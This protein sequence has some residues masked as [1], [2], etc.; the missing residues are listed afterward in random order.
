M[1]LSVTTKDQQLAEECAKNILRS[2]SIPMRPEDR[3]EL[4]KQ[5]VFHVLE[6][7][8]NRDRSEIYIDDLGG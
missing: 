7:F 4:T 2:F 3:S 1:V 8:E 6:A 5:I